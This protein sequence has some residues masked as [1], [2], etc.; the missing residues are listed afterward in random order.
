MSERTPRDLRYLRKGSL[1]QERK[2]FEN[3]F[4]DL[5]YNYG[6]DTIYFRHNTQ[7]PE[8]L[9]TTPKMDGLEDLIYGENSNMEYY[10]SGEMVVYI[11]IENDIFELTKYGLQPNENIT[12][13]FTVND[14]NTKFATE[15]GSKREFVDT[16]QFTNTF[17]FDV[18]YVY[19]EGE[20][21]GYN[22]E[23]VSYDS[24]ESQSI[25][26]SSNFTISG[27]SGSIYTEIPYGSSGSI[28]ISSFDVFVNVDEGYKIPVNKYIAKS[29]DYVV[30]GGDY[31]GASF[32]TANVG[33]S[34][35]ECT[36]RVGVIYY[37]P[38]SPN[39][40]NTNIMPQ[41][42]D[43][44]RMPFF[45]G[46][47]EE[48]EITNIADRIMTADGINPLLGKYIWKCQSVRRAPSHEEVIGGTEMENKANPEIQ[49]LNSYAIDELA[50]SINDYEYSGDDKVYGG[51]NDT[52][53]YL[54]T[55]EINLEDYTVSG[56]VFE[57]DY[58]PSYLLTDGHNLYFRNG[59]GIT[60]LLSDD[61]H[62]S[63]TIPT[64]VVGLKYMRSDGENLYF[65]NNNNTSWKLTDSFMEN[66]Y[67]NSIQDLSTVVP[68]SNG[69]ATNGIHCILDK[70][71]ILFS[72]G[73]N[74]YAVNE[75]ME[76]TQLTRNT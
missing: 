4:K 11:E 35:C 65:V 67:L 74:L 73:I 75:D 56:I 44:F 5:I 76:S 72:D 26:L 16:I 52:G 18:Q 27:L 12:L 2:I 40:Y 8:K 66:E 28:Q 20:E 68:Q 31:M 58:G 32:G 54:I 39:T 7:Y 19:H 69:F 59:N 23:S 1:E 6:V 64:E 38:V 41:V 48:Y 70:G 57:F 45:D 25:E 14:F 61:T 13:Y 36:A 51:Y 55:S 17:S 53:S 10:L 21:V 9:D 50:N 33:T 60:T 63:M 30:K 15:L 62:I 43:F 47:Y 29:E 24:S 37:E 46:T 3:Y 71:F 34:S 49:N 42:G 22:G